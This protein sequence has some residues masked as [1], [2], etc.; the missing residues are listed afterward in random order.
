MTTTLKET[1]VFS[2]LVI[3]IRSLASDRQIII[4]KSLPEEDNIDTMVF[5]VCRD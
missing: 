5:G 2:V 4:G 3:N 1:N